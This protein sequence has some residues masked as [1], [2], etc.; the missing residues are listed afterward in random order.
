MYGFPFPT[1]AHPAEQP[2]TNAN[3]ICNQTS[4][5]K[6]NVYLA[7]AFT[8]KAEYDPSDVNVLY[9]KNKGHLSWIFAQQI[10]Y[11]LRSLSLFIKTR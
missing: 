1:P 2:D 4:P 5:L 3:T 9:L 11:V 6:T 7:L 10:L 8:L